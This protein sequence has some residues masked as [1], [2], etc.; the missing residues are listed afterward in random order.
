[1]NP[2]DQAI[3]DRLIRKRIAELTNEDKVFLRARSPY[4][5]DSDVERLGKVLNLPGYET[6]AK[7]KEVVHDPEVQEPQVFNEDLEEVV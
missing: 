6:P 2:T 4:F 1:M 3:F 5:D 7:T